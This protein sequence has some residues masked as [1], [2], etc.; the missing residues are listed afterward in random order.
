MG[1]N[2]YRLMSGFSESI[3][4]DSFGPG[5]DVEGGL[6][7]DPAGS[8]V[9]GQLDLVAEDPVES[10]R[11]M[12]RDGDN[13]LRTLGSITLCRTLLMAGL[14]DRFRVVVFPVITGSTGRER[15][16][17]TTRTSPSRW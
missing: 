9:V 5:P 1:A 6:L 4:D 13:P 11:V 14:V 12:K 8:A 7:L 16:Y 3:E 2:T 10:V 15:V 17:E